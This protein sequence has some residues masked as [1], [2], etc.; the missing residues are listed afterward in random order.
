MWI[1]R[2]TSRLK[3]QILTIIFNRHKERLL[4]YLN[5]FNQYHAVPVGLPRNQPQFKTSKKPGEP[6][7]LSGRGIHTYI[8]IY[9]ILS[10]S[11]KRL[12]YSYKRKL[13]NSTLPEESWLFTVS[14][15][16]KII[17]LRVTETL[18]WHAHGSRTMKARHLFCHKYSVCT[19][20]NTA[21]NTKTV[22]TSM[23][24]HSRQRLIKW[25]PVVWVRLPP[26]LQSVTNGNYFLAQR[27]PFG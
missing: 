15:P 14:W 21:V 12:A 13:I 19:A 10:L 27:F 1:I 20:A 17:L 22:L 4:T 25:Q 18:D 5:H 6:Q 3:V 16:I 11:G 26:F 8:H 2:W 24:H 23:V 7:R 9:I